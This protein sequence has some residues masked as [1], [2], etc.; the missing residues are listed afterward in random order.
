MTEI[1]LDDPELVLRNL[2]KII[3][4]SDALTRDGT[5]DAHTIY[6]L[7]RDARDAM[8]FDAVTREVQARL[9][10]TVNQTVFR[11][12]FISQ[13]VMDHI[14]NQRLIDA[15]K[16]FRSDSGLGLKEAKDICEAWREEMNITKLSW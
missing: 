4:I 2:Q 9:V 11:G 15:I 7:A 16:Q 8:M 6:V 1:N 3:N 14:R 12:H 5:R 13:T 10:D